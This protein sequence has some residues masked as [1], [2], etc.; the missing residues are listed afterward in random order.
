ML[1]LNPASAAGAD[2][3]RRSA[4]HTQWLGHGAVLL[5]LSGEVDTADLRSVLLGQRPRAGGAFSEASP[6]ALTSRPGLRRRH[7]WDLIFAAPK[8]VS[9]LT[10]AGSHPAALELREAYRSA[11]ND[12]LCT[13]EERAACVRVGGARAAADG[14]VAAAF[15]HVANDAGHPHLHTHLVLANLGAKEGGQW[16]CLISTELWRWREGIGAGFH[17]ALRSRLAEAGLGFNW[18]I[19]P[20][21]FGE[22]VSV[23]SR[24]RL[25]ASSR[26][27]VVRAASRAFGSASTS[28]ERAAQVRSRQASQGTRPAPTAELAGVGWGTGAAVQVLQRAKGYPALPSAPP[29]M[30]AVAGALAARGSAF[31]EPDVLV[32]LAETMPSGCDLRQAT[33][34]ARRWCDASRPLPPQR[35]EFPRGGEAIDGHPRPSAS[36]LWTTALA[37][38]LDRRVVDRATEARFAH[39]AEV[40]PA[41][42]MAELDDLRTP[43]DV[44]S[45]AVRL[46]C[47][48]DGVVLM[49]RGPWLAQ[50]AC[51]DAAR[52]AWQA[53]GVT[54]QL[55]CPSELSA[56]RWRSLT[57]LQATGARGAGQVAPAQVS[58][59][60]VLVVDAADHLSPVSLATLLDRAASSRTKVVLVLGGTV[61]GYGP[62]V[63]RSLDHLAED[64]ANNAAVAS[65][66]TWGRGTVGTANAA[67]SL[68]GIAVHGSLTGTDAVAHVAEAWAQVA[69]AEASPP[70]LVAF[71]PA[72][73]EALNLAARS[74][75]LQPHDNGARPAPL[76]PSG[77]PPA[78]AKLTAEP[79]REVMLGERRYAVGDRVVALRR[80]DRAPSA[81]FGS[82]VSL[83]ARSLTVEWHGRAGTWRGD[84]GPEHA[85]S[86][87]YGYATTVPYLRSLDPGAQRLIVLGDPLELGG[88]STQ[89][90]AA[91]VTVPGPGFPAFGPSGLFAR[92]RAA[93]TE[94]ATSWPDHEMLDLAGPRPLA[95][96]RRRQWAEV[97]VSCAM[98]RDLGLFNERTA[99]ERRDA[100]EMATT[101]AELTHSNIAGRRGVEPVCGPGASSS[102]GP[103]RSALTWHEVPLPRV[104]GL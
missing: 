103:K 73:A 86:L 43:S 56:R 85:R 81:T 60:R 20:G 36:K 42:A 99:N 58:R 37:R 45:E 28:T 102:P 96:A 50:A 25:A 32:A 101:V 90:G 49:P 39:M 71:G 94:L 40:M 51:I 44:V 95:L 82:V 52:A 21:G 70:L 57:S 31:A 24:A 2:Y 97:V 100:H 76:R 59:G 41:L 4:V 29:A 88:R 11:V 91:W 9:L 74:V 1:V 14:V 65:G 54:V 6:Q 38:Q 69:R 104:P 89:A 27:R 35:N 84:V 63:A 66:P 80:I 55:T 5:G 47:G 72:E 75:W 46:A 23:P 19:S 93:L 67:V 33:D 18:E 92:R 22:I 3:W 16:G 15:E 17:L 79:R 68:P 34:W 83:G 12:A 7:G 8:S 53:A 98:R 64:L 78:P 77:M 62:S 48:P 30:T 13:L 61:P 87:G 10:E 26:S